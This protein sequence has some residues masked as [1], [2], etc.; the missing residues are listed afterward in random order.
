DSSLRA[1]RGRSG[2]ARSRSGCRR[3]H[4]WSVV[5]ERHGQASH[6]G[7][8]AQKSRS[9]YGVAFAPGVEDR[10]RWAR[11]EIAQQTDLSAGGLPVP[12]ELRGVP[13]LHTHDQV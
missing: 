10:V 11:E 13:A 5:R 4:T 7:V 8:D 1:W 2:D 3:F 9:E 12:A 6:G